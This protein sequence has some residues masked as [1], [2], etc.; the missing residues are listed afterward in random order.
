MHYLNNFTRIVIRYRLIY[1]AT[2]FLVIRTYYF[3]LFHKLLQ[4]YYATV[5]LLAL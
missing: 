3:F 5:E 1:I 4:Q 2:L